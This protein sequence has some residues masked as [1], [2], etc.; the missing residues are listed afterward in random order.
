MGLYNISQGD[1]KKLLAPQDADRRL[2]GIDD[3][4]IDYPLVYWTLNVKQSGGQT[5]TQDIF[6]SAICVKTCPQ[7]EKK[8][9][10]C[11]DTFA[12]K[13]CNAVDTYPTT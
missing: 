8:I 1:P 12:V 9:S 4:V 5:D 6:A 11:A 13:N 10:G 3:A 7:N 2:C